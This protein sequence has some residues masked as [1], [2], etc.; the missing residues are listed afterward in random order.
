MMGVDKCG[1]IT[2]GAFGSGAMDIL[3]GRQGPH[4]DRHHGMVHDGWPQLFDNAK[5][6]S[7]DDSFK[8]RTSP[9]LLPLNGS[10]VAALALSLVLQKDELLAA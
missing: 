10:F 5:S 1:A 6:C 9:R 8:A 4:H 3:I 7:L 2:G